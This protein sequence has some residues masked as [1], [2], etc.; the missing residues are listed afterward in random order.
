MREQ[1]EAW[2]VCPT[3]TVYWFDLGVTTEHANQQVDE[4]NQLLSDTVAKA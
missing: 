3:V 2:L 1:L 4:A